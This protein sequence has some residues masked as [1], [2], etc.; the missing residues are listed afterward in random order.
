MY[1]VDLFEEIQEGCFPC[2]PNKEYVIFKS[3]V[4][5]VSVADS[6][7]DVAAFEEPHEKIGV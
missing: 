3:C 6:W 2:R 5:A 1:C 4:Q 7:I